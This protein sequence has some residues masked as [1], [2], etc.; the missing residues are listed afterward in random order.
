M[1]SH[2]WGQDT[3]DRKKRQWQSFALESFGSRTEELRCE[4]LEPCKGYVIGDDS[5]TDW[6][7]ELTDLEME[8]S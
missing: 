3:N 2:F 5:E 6:D 8:S 1:G 7:S 4:D